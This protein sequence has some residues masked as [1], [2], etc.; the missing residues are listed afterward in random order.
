MN[1]NETVQF[2]F[3]FGKYLPKIHLLNVL[4]KGRNPL[5]WVQYVLKYWLFHPIKRHVAR[6]WLKI[7]KRRGLEVIAITGSA[8]K[9]TTRSLLEAVL[10]EK[11]NVVTTSENL[12]PIYN[13]PSTI[14]RC[15]FNTQI[16]ILELGIEFPL[17]M[18]HYLWLA[19]PDYA[20]LT[21]LGE[22][23]GEF[24]GGSEGIKIEKLKLVH[25]P[26]VKK[27]Y[28][29]NYNQG[30]LDAFGKINPTKIKPQNVT[31]T[32]EKGTEFRLT[33]ESSMKFQI[34]FLGEQF[35]QN[36]LLVIRIGRD[37]GLTYDKIR[38]GLSKTKL[39]PHR[40]IVH[41]I[42]DWYLIDDSYNSNP[43]A[44]R[45]SLKTLAAVSKGQTIAVLGEMKE[46]GEKSDEYH[47]GIGELIGELKI[48]H[49]IGF[50]GGLAGLLSKADERGVK[51]FKV[52]TVDG[53]QKEIQ[54]LVQKDSIVLVKGS[55]SL[56]ME[57]IVEGMI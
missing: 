17:E 49:L 18:D 24:L 36:A 2:E 1:V 35:V 40:M 53:T 8:G 20:I 21:S 30:I 57:R 19:E 3:W 39:P 10:S 48:T 31:L 5:E 14:L 50:G 55:R 27:I 32:L 9:T 42:D 41:K 7:L 26:S 25:F 29:N 28:L 22:V 15:R 4:P 37:L 12:D 33:D 16:L 52:D 13:I 51:T 34:P 38:V 23:H 54:R 6:F 45:E 43:T 47:L 56:K 46:L 11:F 44:C